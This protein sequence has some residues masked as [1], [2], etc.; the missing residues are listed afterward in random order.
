VGV[1]SGE[2]FLEVKKMVRIAMKSYG[3]GIKDQNLK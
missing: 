2:W 3:V 1:V